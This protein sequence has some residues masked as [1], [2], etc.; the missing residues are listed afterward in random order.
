[1]SVM[2]GFRTELVNKILGFNSHIIVQSHHTI[3]DESQRNKL[4]E[5]SNNYFLSISGEVVLIN[6]NFTKGLAIRGYKTDEFK[7]L[8]IFRK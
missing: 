3:I 2:N 1:M 7:F 4:N 6:K 5:I 8:P